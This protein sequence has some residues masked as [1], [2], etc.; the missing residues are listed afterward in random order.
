MFRTFTWGR[1]VVGIC[2]ALVAVFSTTPAWATSPDAGTLNPTF[3]SNFAA[4]GGTTSFY[5]S[6]VEQPDGKIVMGSEH[7]VRIKRLN[8]DG[9]LDTAFQ[10]ALGFGFNNTVTTVAIHPDGGIL[11]GGFFTQFNGV[12]V[13]P[14]VKLTNSGALDSTFNVN[15]AAAIGYSVDLMGF[16]RVQTIAVSSGQIFVGGSLSGGLAGTTY[17]ARLN[18]DGSLANS[19]YSFIDGTV[20]ALL[21]LADGS[22]LAGGSFSG[23]G[24]S[25]NV[26]RIDATDN[27]DISFGQTLGAPNSYVQALG[28]DASGNIYIGGNFTAIRSTPVGRLAKVSST[29]V[30]DTTFNSNLGSGFDD[31]VLS[32]VPQLDGS[33]FAVGQFQNF[34]GT[35]VG[36]GTQLTSVGIPDATFMS[37]FGT[38]LNNF[39]SHAIRLSTGN[40]LTFGRFGLVNTTNVNY[41][42]AIRTD[43]NFTVRYEPNGGTGS[44]PTN[45]TF[46]TSTTIASGTGLSRPGYSFGGWNAPQVGGGT[47]FSPNATYSTAADLNLFA[48][49]TPLPYSV[50]YS[51]GNGATAQ[52]VGTYSTGG[53][54]TLPAAPTRAGYNFTNWTVTDS[55]STTHVVNQNASY[56]PVGYGNITVAA[57]WTAVAPSPSP[58]PSQT[59]TITPASSSPS[60]LANTGFAPIAL[61]I[62]LPMLAL[63][64]V[65]VRRRTN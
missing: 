56:S 63:G 20:A 51:T 10:S 53:S 25:T 46:L 40:I 24:L 34:N 16:A 50:T 32:V 42:A 47:G 15:A 11:V 64:L 13:G 33:V 22:L 27:I 57:N 23:W 2:C 45:Q 41:L 35:S 31:T 12:N 60:S 38:G 9:T 48:V 58:S 28:Q 19:N 62:A 49:W 6:A 37:N 54:F 55:D 44:I 52:S 29:G 61:F 8:A 3:T 39:H 36:F 65:A 17:L 30:L 14:V 1:F 4:S 26:M 21:P 7:S 5:T 59:S 43:P 18:N